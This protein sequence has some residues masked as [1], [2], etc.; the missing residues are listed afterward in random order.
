MSRVLT[1]IIGSVVLSACTSGYAVAQ[2]QL[3]EQCVE[4]RVHSQKFW[5]D[6][7][8][9]KNWPLPFRA[10]DASS[11]LSY[12][13]VQRNNGWKLH[14]TVGTAMFDPATGVLNDAGEAHIRWIV[15]KAPQDRRIVFVLQGIDAEET[16]KRVEATQ[17][18]ISR[19][20]P[21]GSLPAIYL[22]DEDAPGSAGEYQTAIS[23]AINTS[24]PAP[25]LPV[26]ASA[27]SAGSSP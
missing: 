14:N 21:T 1:L 19:L 7:Y 27:A 24:R 3:N 12:F 2:Q 5:Y 6:Y 8:R 15:S 20:V 25:R 22:T 13:E 18:A 17:V 26:N 10:M 4:D 11:V 23:R 9:N 16:S